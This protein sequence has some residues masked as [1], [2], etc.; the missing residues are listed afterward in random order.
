MVFYR[1]YRP[2]KIADLDSEK[3]RETLFSIFSSSS[4]PH[5]LL[6]TGSKGLGKTSTARIVAKLINCES[7]EKSSIEPC[8]KCDQCKSITAGSN[9][10]ILE[11]DGASNRGID[12]IRDLREKINLSPAK[13]QKKVYIIDEVHMLTTEAFNALLKTLEEP[14]SHAIF[15]LCTTESQKLPPTIT[16]RCF[17]VNFK[18]A[19]AEELTRSFERIAK[20]EGLKIEK[21][22]M[23]AIAQISEGSFRDG[24]KILEEM[25]TISKSKGQKITA[26]LVEEKFN[27]VGIGHSVKEIFKSLENKK[28]KEALLLVAKLSDQETDMKFLLEEIINYLHKILLVKSGVL[29]DL[30]INHTFTLGD[31][32]KLANIF[33]AAVVGLK[34]AVLPQLP[35]EIAILEWCQGESLN[36]EVKREELKVQP[37]KALRDSVK[38]VQLEKV[39]KN[40]QLGLEPKKEEGDS[41]WRDLIDKAKLNN[42]SIAGVL[43][44][45]SLKTWNAEKVII[46]TPYKFHK[47]KLEEREAM[48]LIKKIVEEISGNKVTVSILLKEKK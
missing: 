46:E 35:L 23:V 26:S 33:S 48:I 34:F 47:E 24:A 40:D 6:F 7:K 25:V 16:S 30:D 36:S 2:Q 4:F 14:P 1:K 31:I 18:K 10:D 27:V 32:K 11:I 8:N 5:A 43:R 19:T 38:K 20:G 45:G 13:T 3:I 12:E 44:G 21:E 15:I 41:L 39:I 28:S 29:Q 17:G 22:A 9:M 37:P 42:H